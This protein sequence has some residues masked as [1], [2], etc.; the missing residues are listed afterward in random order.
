MTEESIYICSC[1]GGV[2]DEIEMGIILADGIEL[3]WA[4]K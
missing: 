2:G 4:Q 3:E 1:L